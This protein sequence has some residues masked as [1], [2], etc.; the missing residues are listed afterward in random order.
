MLLGLFPVIGGVFQVM[1]KPVLGGAT[2]IM[3]GTVASSGIKII[4]KHGLDRRGVMILALSFGLGLGVQM[5]PGVMNH[6][7]TEKH[8]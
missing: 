3:F 8:L 6:F 1:P 2:L 5:V 4:T 7:P